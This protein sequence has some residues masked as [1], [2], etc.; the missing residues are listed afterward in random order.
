[1]QYTQ[2]ASNTSKLNAS[3]HILEKVEIF[4]SVSYVSFNAIFN[5]C[6]QPPKTHSG[7]KIAWSYTCASDMNKYF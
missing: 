3:N 2:N 7:L 6:H 4:L 1:M 5:I